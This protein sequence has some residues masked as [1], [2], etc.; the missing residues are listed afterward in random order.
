MGPGWMMGRGGAG[1]LGRERSRTRKLL[2][3]IGAFV[4]TATLLAGASAAFAAGNF[5]ATG[6]DMDLHCTSGDL[7]ECAYLKIVVDRVR[8]G[9]SRPILAIDQG[10]QVARALA[11]SGYTA[12]GQVVTVDP[13][14]AAFSATPFVDGSGNPRYSAIITASDSTCGGCD[15]TPAGEAAINARASDFAVFLNKGGGILALAGATNFAGYYSFVPL[16]VAATV[17]SGPFTVTSSGA[18]LGITSTMANCCATHNSFRPPSS[19]FVILENDNAGNAETIAALNTTITGG[20]FSS[21][22][23]PKPPVL[24]KSFNISPVSGKVYVKVPGSRSGA[25]PGTGPGYVAL[26]AVQSLPAGSQIDSRFGNFKLTSA[27][28]KKGNLFSGTFGGAIVSVS[29]VNS[30]REKGL[31]TFKLLLGAFPGAP[32]LKGCSTKA[33][34]APAGGGPVAE[35]ASL[36]S[37]YHSRSHGRY[38]TRSGRSSGSS[39]G[40]QWDTINRCNGVLY[41]VFRGTV[42][43]NDGARHKIVSVTAGHSYLAKR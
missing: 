5:I 8:N 35:I 40:T 23:P 2:P 6:H 43:V 20:G 3:L 38:R 22:G 33:G 18:G 14:S 27:T 13:T 30:G 32:N 39:S 24:G 31:T 41:K 17:V 42:V 26:T 37:V 7:N 1:I 36:S 25:V 4:A 15:N 29:Q 16:G 12:P 34:R 9:S 10:S 19:P 21:G 28:G 11:A